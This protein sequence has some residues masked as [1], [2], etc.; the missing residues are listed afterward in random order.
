MTIYKGF[1]KVLV[2]NGD[3]LIISHSGDACFNLSEG[4]SMTCDVLLD[5]SIAKRFIFVP[6]LAK[7]DN[8]SLF[9]SG[10]FIKNVKSS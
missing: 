7:N 2:G 8:W 5:P 4:C 1:D 9:T 10:Y 6:Q 3:G